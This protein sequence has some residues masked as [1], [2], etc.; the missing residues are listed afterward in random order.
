VKN[1][2]QRRN[3]TKA[4]GRKITVTRGDGTGRGEC[5]GAEWS[6][7]QD[8][9]KLQQHSWYEQGCVQQDAVLTKEVHRR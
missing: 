6:Q 3:R 2:R 8:E 7:P 1:K 4:S 9:R 5:R